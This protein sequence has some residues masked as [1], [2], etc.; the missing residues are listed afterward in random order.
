[1]IKKMREVLRQV[2]ERFTRRDL[3]KVGGLGLTGLIVSQWGRSTS[4]YE[5][6][7]SE[8]AV[9]DQAKERKYT[10]GSEQ[11]T[12][13]FPRKIMWEMAQVLKEK[14]EW[15][16]GD[17][18]SDWMSHLDVFESALITL[19]DSGIKGGRLVIA[20]YEI[21]K[22]GETYDWTSI[23]KAIELMQKHSMAVDLSVGPFNTA[24]YP[25][26]RLPADLQE[27]LREEFTQNHKRDIHI[28]MG[29]DPAMPKSSLAI[30]E[31]GIHFVTEL[32]EKY[33]K[34]KRIDKFYLSNEW[35]DRQVIEGVEI[36]DR[37]G[38]KLPTHLTV[39]LDYMEKIT[40]LT[41][42][43]TAKKI[44]INTNIHPSDLH[45]LRQKLGPILN[46]LGNQ[47]VLG[48]DIY[49]TRE[50]EDFYLRSYMNE[51][52]E[53]IHKIRN[54]FPDTE[55]VFTELQASPWPEGD[56]NGKSWVDIYRLDPNL[57]INYYRGFFPTTLDTHVL[58][59]NI[60]EVGLW[61]AEVIVV[62]AALGYKFPSKLFSAIN[63]GMEKRK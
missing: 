37:K 43:G 41:Q 10:P 63:E 56:L 15:K 45:A 52:D 62:L 31:F 17:D 1:M 12:T 14:G 27:L 49:P 5:S 2:S 3:L 48:L 57:I 58:Q 53:L 51:Y 28:S 20:P 39:D 25:G 60:Q 40:E 18:E 22:D 44:A 16:E 26:V 34:D 59:S 61:G 50:A 35:P 36:E 19:K 24:Y 32:M 8:E 11:R 42:A 23:E 33:G 21:P 47:G 54:A 38:H 29:E 6:L 55:L 13:I 4:E 30:R 46:K 9:L 7:P